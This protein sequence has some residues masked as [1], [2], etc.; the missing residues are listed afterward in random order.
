[1]LRRLRAKD[2]EWR[3]A[4]KVSL[5]YF[6]SRQDILIFFVLILRVTYQ[7]S[8]VIIQCDEEKEQRHCVCGC[9]GHQHLEQDRTVL[10]S[11]VIV[12]LQ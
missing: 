12:L 7:V 9:A 3:D 1:M 10:S 2:D 11:S 5:S 8:F 6:S 4:Q